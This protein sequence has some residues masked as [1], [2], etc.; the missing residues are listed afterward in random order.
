M[1]AHLATEEADANGVPPPPPPLHRREGT[2][3]T[4][5]ERGRANANAD[6]DAHPLT[7]DK[8]TVYRGRRRS[9]NRRQ[10]EGQ[11]AEAWEPVKEI[12]GGGGADRGLP[13]MVGRT[14]TVSNPSWSGGLKP[15]VCIGPDN[16]F[17]MSDAT[18]REK[19]DLR[20]ALSFKSRGRLPRVAPHRPILKYSD[21]EAPGVEDDGSDDDSSKRSSSATESDGMP[22]IVTISSN[23]TEEHLD[24]V[25]SWRKRR[26][27][28]TDERRVGA[29]EDCDG[30]RLSL[31]NLTRCASSLPPKCAIPTSRGKYAI[32]NFVQPVNDDDIRADLTAESTWTSS[33]P[34]HPPLKAPTSLP[35][36]SPH[37][38]GTAI[39]VCLLSP[40]TVTG[41]RTRKSYSRLSD[42]EARVRGNEGNE[43]VDE[44]VTAV[45][46]RAIRGEGP[47]VGGCYESWRNPSAAWAEGFGSG[48]MTEEP[49]P[50]G[51]ASEKRKWSR[52]RRRG[53]CLESL[54]DVRLREG[55][56]G[57]YSHHHPSEFLGALRKLRCG[58]TEMRTETEM[59]LAEWE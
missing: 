37:R 28:T 43:N 18:P 24:A 22:G 50:L 39:L 59:A 30:P 52:Q 48:K 9:P 12:R 58:G 27:E 36:P 33:T 44:N 31:K 16:E 15:R 53:R 55:S 26:G 8:V 45:V 21:L 5:G 47:E 56:S 41:G 49:K 32:S 11:E 29:D 6:A 19:R 34:H 42:H 1:S 13:N 7:A 35:L 20:G 14:V 38:R 46:D 23:A 54:T 57:R 25:R 10:S 3:I 51:I 40:R 4:S 2:R 17:F